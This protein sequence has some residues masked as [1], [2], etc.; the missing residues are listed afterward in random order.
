MNDD[1]RSDD[2]ARHLATSPQPLDQ[3]RPDTDLLRMYAEAAIAVTPLIRQLVTTLA[4]RM[5]II[6]NIVDCWQRLPSSVQHTY[7]ASPAGSSLSRFAENYT[8]AVEADPPA[9]DF[10]P[11]PSSTDPDEDLRRHLWQQHLAEITRRT[12]NDQPP[13]AAWLA[14]FPI[15]NDE[16]V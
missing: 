14:R 8:D 16:L 3:Q 1:P 4:D 2:P 13:P 6:A 5:A 12:A 11:D 9:D 10:V 15:Q 7:R